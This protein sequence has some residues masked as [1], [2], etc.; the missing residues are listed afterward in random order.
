M[1]T[2]FLDAPDVGRFQKLVMSHDNSGFGAAWKL[3]K[4]DIVNTNTG[5]SCTFPANR[6][7]D[8]EHGLSVTLTPDRDGDGVGDAL[9][10]G[11]EADFKV[12]VYT[13]DIRRVIGWRCIMISHLTDCIMGVTS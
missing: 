11:P 6:W 10:G 5:E 1:D 7:L 13:S 2:F 4:V 12:T 9:E 3:S 8:Q